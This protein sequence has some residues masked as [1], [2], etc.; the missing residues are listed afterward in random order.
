MKHFESYVSNTMAGTSNQLFFSTNLDTSRVFYKI[1]KGGKYNYALV[2]TNT[3][4]STYANGAVCQKNVICSEWELHSAR[5]A[6]VVSDISFANEAELNA[7]NEQI[8]AFTSLTFDGKGSKTVAPAEIFA[9]D[10]IELEFNAG[11]YLCVEITYSGEKIPYHEEAIIP[12]CHKVDTGW[13]LHK[14]MPLPSMV[15]VKRSVKTKIG[16]IGDSITQGIGVPFNHYT[17][18]NALVADKLGTDYGFWNLGIGFG[19]ANDIASLGAWFSKALQNDVL[20]VCYGVNDTMQG[21]S[22]EQLKNDLKTTVLALKEAGKRVILQTIPPFDYN[23]EQRQRWQEVNCYIKEELSR[24]VDY[25]FDVVPHLGKSES[26]PH[27]AKYGGHPNE[28]GCA[29]WA[30]ALYEAIKDII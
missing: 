8:I 25:V 16:F 3:I 28:Q 21:F 6:R 11:D 5:V 15:G 14:K 19:R 13:R 30:N 24:S 12:I 7:L 10:E 2:F 22:K 18:W 20:V 26:E 4:D 29:I 17:H 9:S 27:L 1:T 23:P